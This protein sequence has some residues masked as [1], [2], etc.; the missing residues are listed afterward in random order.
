MRPLIVFDLDGTLIDSKRDLAESANEM[1]AAYGAT[2]LAEKD[3]AGFVGDGARQLVMR[4]LEA[5]GVVA[6]V[7]GALDRFLEI[8]GG[9]L[10]VHTRLYPGVTEAVAAAKPRCAL[11]VLTNKP[12]GFARQLLGGFGLSPFFQWVIGGD[13]G[14]PRKPDPSGLSH[15][16]QQA[17]VTARACLMVGDSM[18]DVETARAAGASV[19]IAEYGFGHLRR[20][21]ERNGTEL[22][23]RRSEDLASVVDRFLLGLEPG[24]W[25]PEPG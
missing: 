25:S 8:Y 21:I 20:P 10:F 1:L 5:A 23:A 17:G 19:C 9:R 18:V 24:G 7:S 3:V 11:A 4:A 13:S 6:D 14:F 15:V 12:E 2:P 16:I 22:V